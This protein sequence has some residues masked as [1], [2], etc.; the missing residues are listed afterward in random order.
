MSLMPHQSAAA[1]EQAVWLTALAQAYLAAGDLD[2][3]RATYEQVGALTTG[4]L[5]WGALYARSFYQLG[6]IAQRQGDTAR[7]REHF[8]K[9]LEIWKDADPGLPEVPDAK[10]RLAR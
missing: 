1:D 8:Q 10:R 9:F 6:L 2:K 4:R 3:A 7:A 5:F